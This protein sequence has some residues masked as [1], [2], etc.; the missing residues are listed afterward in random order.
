MDD[1]SVT[2]NRHLRSVSQLQ[3]TLTWPFLN[4]AQLKNDNSVVPLTMYDASTQRC[5]LA[6]PDISQ[7]SAKMHIIY[8]LFIYL[9]FIY[10][11]LFTQGSLFSTQTALQESPAQLKYNL[12]TI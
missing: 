9:L 8:T 10:S 7:P 1:Q 4:P 5:P 6:S 3:K 11:V 2:K 12:N